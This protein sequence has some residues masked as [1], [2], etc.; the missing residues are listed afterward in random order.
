MSGGTPLDAL[1]RRF[2]ASVSGAL[3]PAGAAAELAAIETEI[4]ARGP[5]ETAT[6]EEIARWRDRTGDPEA[7]RLVAERIAGRAAAWRDERPRSPEERF[8]LL[9]RAGAIDAEAIGLGHEPPLAEDRGAPRE[10]FLE[11][12]R[13]APADDATRR[14]WAR[15]LLDR[16]DG[17][18]LALEELPRDRAAS[19][20]AVVEE[21]LAWH[22]RQVD[23]GRARFARKLRRIRAER[24]ERSLQ[25]ALER[26]FGAARVERFERLL[27]LLLL[28]LLGIMAADLFANLSRPVYVALA[29]VEAACCGVFLWEF[30]VKMRFAEDRLSYF[31][32][33]FLVDLVP[34]IPFGLLLLHPSIWDAAQL[35][36][37]A[38][39]FRLPRMAVYVAALRPALRFLRAFGFLTRG[40]DRLVRQHGA[41][42]NRD[43]IVDPT[44]EER[45][46]AA[47][48]GERRRARRLRASI[49]RAFAALHA[50]APPGERGAILA[51]R[52][53][54]FRAAPDAPPAARPESRAILAEELLARLERISPEEIEADLGGEATATIA[55]A[56]RAFAAPPLRWLPV[57]RGYAPRLAPGTPDAEA[58]AAAARRLAE[59][60]QRKLRRRQWIADLHGA[61]SPA[62]FVDRVGTAMV[63][64]SFRPAWRLTIFGGVYLLI[65]LLFGDVSSGVAGAVNRFLDRTLGPF[66]LVLG[67][68]C[69]VVLGVGIWLRRIA[70]QATDFFEKSA[71]AQFLETAESVKGR[72]ID[73]DAAILERRVVAAEEAL[74]GR[75]PSEGAAERRR[76][77]AT[78][79]REWLLE[80]QAGGRG[81]AAFD[82]LERCVLLY[83]EGLDGP[84]LGESDTATTAQLLGSPS[85]RNLRTE[86]LRL[87][88]AESRAL[89]RLDLERPRT[90]LRGPYF[91]F[92][93][94]SKTLV[95]GAAQL[96][97][98]FNRHAIPADELPRATADAR[99]EHEAWLASDRA[100]PVPSDEVLYRTTAFTILH[101]LDDDPRRDREVEARFGARVL[102][103]L[104]ENRRLLFRKTF[105]TRPNH[106][107][108]RS[109]RSI[110][111]YEAHQRWLAGGRALLLPFRLAAA[112]ARF[113]AEVVRA[114]ARA[115]KEIR[116][117]TFGGGRAEAESADFAVA[118]RKIRRM[119]A[120]VVEAATLLRA[121]CDPEYLDV[122]IPGLPGP[123]SCADCGGDLAFLRAPPSLE[124]RIDE[125]RGRSARDMAR[126]ARLLDEGLLGRI[127]ALLGIEREA[128]TP[129]QVRAA[130]VA[131]ACDLRG[132]RRHLSAATILREV[133]AS[134]ESR[135]PLPGRLLPRF[136][137][138][139][140]FDDYWAVQGSRRPGARLRAWRA[141][142]HD[143]DGVA[144][145]LLAFDRFGDVAEREGESI[146]ADIL[147]HPSRVTDRLVTLRAVQTLSLIDLLRYREHVHRLGA[148]GPAAGGDLLGT[149]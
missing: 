86:S 119:R 99:R 11:A 33:H 92:S 141:T 10:A 108:G 27:F 115:V 76:R 134:A 98:D 25:A 75:D 35:G 111:L 97:V 128:I 93:L 140:A 129:E 56:A 91:W 147:R 82:P 41:L 22:A 26:R 123:P 31:K 96:V 139:R 18:L 65:Q 55:R 125:E 2:R 9:A 15:E 43:V 50:Q 48:G 113:A 4:F 38:R 36:R 3:P 61:I 110:N 71:R 17:A 23:A 89:A 143:L 135:P 6:L 100:A 107:R 126:F 109:E 21:D 146:L 102:E 34:S 80:A 46:E 88:R 106:L 51:A 144:G 14:R 122:A 138:S 42:L 44:R 53:A 16:A 120:P 47:A 66:L 62:Q 81:G 64:S 79:V 130:A 137:L 20:L 133:F 58:A 68:V 73:R 40:A 12:L 60:L 59:R 69:V 124:R 105:G 7:A 127:A 118:E 70:G 103:R 28:L 8:R 37:A 63:K 132:A 54:A 30:A 19:L 78:G 39:L 74:L 5:G 121:R 32:R 67:S 142:L 13:A 24:Q 85:L 72:A 77:I 136:G 116:H 87:S 95:Q 29:A 90:S 145:A 149:P 49:S 52:A 84:I 117:P 101:F 131:Y 1:E 104:R 94:L 45:A 114:L 57:L 148:Y 112:G 83:R